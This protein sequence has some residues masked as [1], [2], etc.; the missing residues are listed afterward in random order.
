MRKRAKR[1]LTQPAKDAR[2][3]FASWPERSHHQGL[4]GW[5][6]AEAKRFISQAQPTR[7]QT[8]GAQGSERLVEWC[9]T[10]GRCLNLHYF[11]PLGKHV[12]EGLRIRPTSV[13][14]AP[15]GAR[16]LLMARWAHAA[17]TNEIDVNWRNDV[18]VPQEIL[19]NRRNHV[20]KPQE[21]LVNWGP[22]KP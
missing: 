5:Y 15:A 18:S 6:Y 8:R 4:C 19:V 12:A 3:D 11:R 14:A 22:C 20:T 2:C 1:M 13:C 7:M 9:S 17:K 16:V 21:I 10:G